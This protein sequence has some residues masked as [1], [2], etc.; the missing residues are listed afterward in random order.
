MFEV[1]AETPVTIPVV[2][3]MVAIPG[4]AELHEPPVEPSLKVVVAPAQTF[5]TPVIADGNGLMVTTAIDLQPVE[6]V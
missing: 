4:N 6:R 2:E 1:P 3:P 5:A